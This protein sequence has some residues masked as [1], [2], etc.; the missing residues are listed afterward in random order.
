MSAVSYTSIP[1]KVIGVMGVEPAK[2]LYDGVH[3]IVVQTAATKV[4]K[5]DYDAHAALIAEKFERL[6]EKFE[7]IDEK[8]DRVRLETDLK[9]SEAKRET[10]KW[11]VAWTVTLVTLI[12]GGWTTVIIS[13]LKK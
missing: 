10:I 2:Q 4:D 12:T 5:G 8:L 6:D 9:I 3:Q 7:R 13:F 11:T 1:E